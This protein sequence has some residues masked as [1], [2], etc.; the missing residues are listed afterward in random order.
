MGNGV[1]LRDKSIRIGFMLD[2][3]WTRETLKLPPTPANEK[4]AA[5]LVL[6]IN[7]RIEAGTF[8]YA[9]FFPGSKKAPKVAENQTFGQMCGLWLQT[10]GQKATNTKTQY[11]NALEVWKDLFGAETPF[12]KLSHGT[13]A[14]K[15]GDTPWKSPKL[16]NNYLIP[17]RGVFALAGR[18]LKIEDPMD[19]IVNSKHQ[20]VPPDP[21]SPDEMEMVLR[22]LKASYDH[23]VWAYYEFAFMTGMRPEELI[24]LRW[25]DVD[26]NHGTIKVE[27]AKTKGKI[28]PLKTYQIRDVDLVARALGALQ[29]MKAWTMLKPEAEIFQ[30]IVTGRSWYDERSQRDHY[31]K[32]SLRR[33]GIRQRRSY[34]TRHTYATNAL[35]GGVNPGYVARQMGHKSTKM[36][37]EVYSKWIDGA[38]RGREKAKLEAMLISLTFPRDDL[39]IGRRDWTRTNPTG[40][41]GA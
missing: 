38:D 6:L 26:W 9:E 34:Q 2:G 14:A 30:N 10:K 40:G 39:S 22:D 15:I 23:R 31:W 35:S 33:Q 29:V 11:R 8:D 25:S 28:G 24:A 21:L 4:H 19:G 27:R 3:V 41:N 1:E 20:K 32:P 16:L 18:E 37:F 36:L 5:R 13:V 12:S 17:L 7:K